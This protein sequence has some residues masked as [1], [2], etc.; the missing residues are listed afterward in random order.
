[1]LSMSIRRPPSRAVRGATTLKGLGWILA[2]MTSVFWM[3][4]ETAVACSVERSN[5]DMPGPFMV[6][7]SQDCTESE[8]EAQA[9]SV[10]DLLKALAQHRSVELERVV[11]V[12]DVTFD[13]LPAAKPEAVVLP[14]RAQRKVADLKVGRMYVIDGPIA[15]RNSMVRGT[16]KTKAKDA[17]VMIRGAVIMTGTTFEGMVD[18]S[19]TIF[20]NATDF[21]TSVLLQQGFFIESLFD[22]PARF[23]ETAFGVHSRFHKATFGEPVTF[24]RAGFNGLSEFLEVTF[25]KD[26]RFSQTYFKHATGFSGSHFL[27]TADFSEATFEREAYFSF[28]VFDGDAYFRRATFKAEANFADA[29]FKGLDDFSKTLFSH[30]P[31]FTRVKATGERAFPKGLQDA[32]VLYVIAASL[33]AFS[34]LFVFILRKG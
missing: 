3:S 5:R 26:A 34:L 12:G 1:M 10:A 16:I 4:G 7:L 19:R 27:A 17:V 6:R 2:A 8:R 30:E 33:F 11:I 14:S 21:S 28:G 31:R 23:E 32:R 20:L 9:V 18:L 13:S 25:E 22:Q 15:I 29:E 24:H